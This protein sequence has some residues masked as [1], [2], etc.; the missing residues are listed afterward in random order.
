MW[1]RILA[2][3]LTVL[4]LTQTACTSLPKIEKT[5]EKY[6]SAKGVTI[7]DTGNYYNVV[8]DFLSGLSHRQIGEA[9]GRAIL[10]VVPNYEEIVDSYIAE[11]VIKSEYKYALFRMED[12][13]PQ[14]NPDYAQELE[15]MAS[16]FSGGDN[17][18]YNDGKIS[19][20]EVYLFNLFTDVIRG[21]QCSYISVY[22]NRSATGKTI[23]TRN[24]DWYGG[25]KNQL[26]QI[27]SVIS[28][29]YPDKKICSIGFLGFMGIITGFNDKKVFTGILD[30]GSNAS[31]TAEGRRSYPLDL[32][33]ALETT[34]TMLDA[35]EYMRD[36]KK[37]YTFNHI[38]GFSDP[39]SSIILENNFSGSGANGG[40]VSRAIRKSDSD[41]N[42]GIEWGISDAIASVNAFMIKG[43][44]DNYSN[45]KYN[46]KR[47][48][49]IRENLISMGDKVSKEQL[50]QVASEDD[51]IPGT[52]TESGD[53]YN[54][55]TLH[56]AI[57]EPDDLSLEVFFR[58]RST[59]ENPDIPKF[60]KI[61]VFK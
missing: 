45:N 14:I 35:A 11:N 43:N 55:M 16:V 24:L 17:N 8:L 56:I 31:Y 61:Q 19:I 23:T 26:P 48:K 32:R 46:T 21:T 18:L 6:Y 53:V 54:R 25:S 27:Q 15:G 52:F 58:S 50:E 59:G 38:L 40:R 20:D 5:G 33:H 36:S 44:Y 10:K 37:L 51:G 3:C 7:S 60:E 22:G 30:S 2:A 57:F 41:L 29:I 12:I 9:F 4:I 34:K 49:S 13:K 39:E 28:Y 47:W 42:K 1:K